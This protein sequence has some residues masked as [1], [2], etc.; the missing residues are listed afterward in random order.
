M[1]YIPSKA[2]LDLWILKKTDHYEYIA[3]FVDDVI[4]FSKDPLSIMNELKT[5]Y[6]MKAVGTPEY[7]LGGNVIQLGEEWEKEGISAALSAETYIG[8]I[9]E[10]LAKMVGVPEFP[11]G[12]YKTPM[13]EEYYSELDET[14]F[15]SP[16][17]GSKYRSLIG[18]ANW[19][20][21]L[22]RFDIAFA[23]STLA[24]YST[25]PRKGHYKEAQRI[26]SF[27][28]KFPHGRILIDSK[29]L[30]IRNHIKYERSEN[31]G[32]FYPEAEEDIPKDSLEPLGTTS[33]VTCYVDADH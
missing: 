18:S 7:Y 5:T 16:L 19:I 33:T 1:G 17:E 2:Y 24:R 20:V 3:R 22:G 13:T 23:T 10:K 25:V 14:G 12:R 28:R 32:E 21:A 8:N 9:V 11:K 31:W 15:C 4:S 26:F 27:L 30:P 6:V 29:D